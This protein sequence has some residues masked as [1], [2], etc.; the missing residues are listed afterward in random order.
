[1]LTHCI[2]SELESEQSEGFGRLPS[3]WRG[4]LST[5]MIVGKRVVNPCVSCV[6]NKHLADCDKYLL[7]FKV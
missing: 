7:K 6:S 1:M 4:P 3:F 5:S 2:P